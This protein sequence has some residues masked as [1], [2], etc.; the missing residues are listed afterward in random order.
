MM[1]RTIVQ[2]QIETRGPRVTLTA[3]AAA[4]LVVDA[5]AFVP[6]GGDDAQAAHA[7][8]RFVVLAELLA[9]LGYNRFLI[10]IL[11]AG[12]CVYP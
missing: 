12:H 5:A 9:Q 4:Q 10:E 11:Q 8:H 3:G 2:A 1:A 7:H 6:L